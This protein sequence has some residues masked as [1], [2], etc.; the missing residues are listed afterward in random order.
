MAE[1]SKMRAS[2]LVAA[3]SL[4][5]TAGCQL[6]VD[7]DGLEDMHCGPNE[8]ACPN[9][10]VPRNDPNTGC[11][12]AQCA[13]CAPPHAKAACGTNYQCILDGCVA[14]W[15]DCDHIYENGCEIDVAHDAY[16]C[17]SCDMK[18]PKPDNGIAGCSDKQCTIGGCNPGFEDCNQQYDDGCEHQIWTDQECLTCGLPCPDGTHCAQGVCM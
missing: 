3:V 5:L 4:A 17:G 6:F 13:P 14:D 1:V 11:G 9:G 12:L 2:I 16:N 15:K 7:L 18:C 8:K 10:C